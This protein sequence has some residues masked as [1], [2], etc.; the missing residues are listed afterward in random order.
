[1]GKIGIIGG[2]GLYKIEGIK[3]VKEISVTTP[4]G[5]PS[6]KFILGKLEGKE[7]VFVPRH[8]RGHRIPPSHI[9]YRANIFGMKKLGVERIISVTA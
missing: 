3:D 9:N 1:M 6:G 7:V 8:D 2:S 4:F 5:K